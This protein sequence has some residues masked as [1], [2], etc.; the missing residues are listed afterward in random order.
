MKY[1]Y[2]SWLCLIAFSSF[3]QAWYEDFNDE[4]NGNTSGTSA[5]TPGGTW[6]TTCAGCTGS[7]SKTTVFGEE[8]L[9]IY[10]TGAEA[11]FSSSIVNISSLRDLVLYIETGTLFTESGDYLNVYYRLDNGPEVL[12]HSQTVGGAL[13]SIGT[14][15]V[16]NGSTLQIVARILNNGIDDF[17]TIDNVVMSNTLFSRAT[18]N[19]NVSGTWSSLAINGSSCACT[20]NQYTRVVVGGGNTVTISGASSVSNVI[21]NGTASGGGAGTL[22]FSGNF[23]LDIINAGSLSIA[24]GGQVNGNANANSRITFTD[25]RA[26][27]IVNNGAISIGDILLSNSFFAIDNSS[28]TISGAGTL[29]I[30]DDLLLTADGILGTTNSFTN[31]QTGSF[32]VASDILFSGGTNSSFT[33][34][35][36]ITTGRIFFDNSNN[37]IANNGT[38]TCTT[39]TSATNADDDNVF[40]N[41]NGAV[42][43]ITTFDNTSSDFDILNSGTVNQSGN[44]SNISSTDTN[45]DNLATGVWNWTL[46][47]NTTFDTDMVTVLDCT[48]SGNTF[49]YSAAGSQRIIPVTYHHLTLSNSGAKD[50]NNASFAVRGN[51]LVSG[52]ASFTEGTGTITLSGAGSQTVTNPSGETFNNLI[53][54]NSFATSPQITFNNAVTVIG[55]LTMTDGNVN[56][57][58]NT[59]TLGS[60]TASPGTLSHA[61]ASTNG[62]MYGGTIQRYFTAGTTITVGTVAGFFPMGTAADFKP[63]FLGKNN[64][65]NSGGLLS[66]S[67][68]NTNEST[69]D[70]SIAD[71]IGTIIRRH[72]SFWT[73]AIVSGF[74]AGT[75]S[76][77][78]GGTGF[79]SITS[80]DHLRLCQF[81]SEVGT[82]S[83]PNSGTTTSPLINKTTLT[84]ANLANNFY[85]GSVNAASPLPIVLAYF[86]AELKE[87]RVITTWLTRQ[88]IDNDFFTVQKTIDFETFYEVAIIKGQGTSREEHR[89]EFV[90]DSPF[91]G[92]SYY[93]LKQTD[94]DGKFTYSDPVMINNEGPE[95]A[96]LSVYPN[97]SNGSWFKVEIKGLKDNPAVPIHI[98]NQQGQK[99]YESVLTENGPGVI[100]MELQFGVALPRG[101]YIVKAGKTLQLTRKIAVD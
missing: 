82:T 78:A 57:S 19:W 45:Y 55:T 83:L 20:P 32:S 88:E 12:F 95:S 16:L 29:S 76:I 54:N 42:F 23:A 91:L 28:L 100:D 71:D 75:F 13:T 85:V 33:N 49:N 34:N 51:W 69:S 84:A 77:R 93:R 40:T 22:A 15:P 10:A 8:Y 9:E 11:T 61:L 97:P 6:S 67:Y 35:Q 90:D 65:A 92:Q 58:S 74:S 7:I 25:D 66:L 50:A 48:A 60:S 53:I 101:V 73:S 86:K 70:V 30:T 99:V 26:H 62:W 43:N 37:T 80:V 94:F 89:Y 72:N 1:V 38:I 46:T 27:T 96:V 44:F 24:S 98:Y 64:V 14:S 79:G 39:L 3:S 4:A 68:N 17:F 56:L 63:F 21:V 59:F 36:T 52:T 81:S 41:S 47:P 5:G 87:D 2:L 18:A 31:N